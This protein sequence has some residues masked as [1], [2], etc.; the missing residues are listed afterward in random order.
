[1]LI[2]VRRRGPLFHEIIRALKREGAPVGGADRLKLSEHGVFEDLM[3]LARFARFT[4]D[5]L[6]LAGVLRG[7]FCDIGEEALFELAHG[8]EGGLWGALVR[9]ASERPEWAAA[10]RFL[11][12][13]RDE[14]ARAAPFDFYSRVLDRLD[15]DG[16][17]MRQRL[18]TRMGAEG[19]DAVDAFLA[20]TLAAEDRGARDLETFLGAMSLVEIEVKREAEDKSTAGVGEV[21]VMTVHGAKGLE[22]PIVILPDTSAR[23]T[24]RGGPL[25]ETED[26]GFLWAPRKDDDCPASAAARERRAAAAERESSRLL[27]VALTRARDR[28]I[29]CGVDSQKHRYERSW[30]DYMQRAFDELPIRPFALEGGGEGWRYGLDPVPGPRR[31][32]IAPEAAASPA[33]IRSLAPA[34]SPAT[35]YASPSSLDE[36][37]EG[38]APSPISTLSG[39][40]RYRRGDLIH[41]LLQWLPDL[42]Q[43]ERAPAA[44]RWLTRER[45]LSEDQRREIA[46]AAFGVLDD[47]VFAA[48]FGPG[49]K[50]EVALA[51]RAAGLALSGRVDRLVVEDNRVL[52]I[53]FKTNR[54]AP[55]RVED[56][57][58]A[59][60]RQMALYAELLAEV[61]PGRT[62]EAALVWTDGPCLMPVP[63]GLMDQA[64]ADLVGA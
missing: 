46:G 62:I 29:L 6:T 44:D 4:G 64:V 2:L 42:P 41:R 61:F 37:P 38:A 10:V 26:G 13:A 58:L 52:V 14:A 5:D 17:S 45:D 60:I 43:A 35:R 56:A 59:Y 63:R 20:E 27:Y 48:A 30:R 15:G 24:D 53:D 28:L 34:E 47:P 25:M 9:R 7:P 40:G 18:L 39:L 23:A 49:S 21:R 16:R 3:A 57:D 54:P 22:G 50:A 8:R 32:A 1:L 36:S 55:A 33:W 31:E 11:A 51:G 12:W 19:V